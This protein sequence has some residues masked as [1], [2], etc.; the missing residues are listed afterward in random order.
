[1]KIPLLIGL[2]SLLIALPTTGGAQFLVPGDNM[3]L[4]GIPSIP[5]AIAADAGRYGQYRSARFAEWHPERLEMLVTTRFGNTSQVHRVAAPGAA[6][7]QLTFFDEPVRSVSSWV[8]NGLDGEYFTYL[9]DV[10]GAEFYQLYRHDLAAGRST[11]LSDGTKRHSG[12]VLSRAGDRLAY[13][14]RDAD[15]EGAFTQ[16]RIIDPRIP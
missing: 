9:R 14:R 10:G 8:S 6:R 12:G 2:S 15:A 16:I 11:L 7:E 1:M 3:T 5:I 13:P 4:D